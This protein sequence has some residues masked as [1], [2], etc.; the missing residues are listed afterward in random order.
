MALVKAS[1]RSVSARYEYGPFGETL[2][3]EETGV[4][5]PFRFSTKYLDSETGWYYY[6]YRYYDPVTGRWPSRDPIEE[7][8][9][10]NLYAFVKNKA[11]IAYDLLGLVG[12]ITVPDSGQGWNPPG[13]LPPLPFPRFIV[14]FGFITSAVKSE[15]SSDMEV[16]RDQMIN[17]ARNASTPDSCPDEPEEGSTVTVTL[18]PMS[19]SAGKNMYPTAGFSLGEVTV[20]FTGLGTYEYDCCSKKAISYSI[21]IHGWFS[22]DVDE[23]VNYN[24]PGRGDTGITIVGAF[25][26][27]FQGNF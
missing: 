19:S 2:V 27:T 26:K 9:G 6:G 8:G 3:V 13:D 4:S 15:S 17:S 18:S 10:V 22:D 12:S 1:D 16:L 21:T 14:A 20:N 11:V 24:E 25:E 5:N 23:L 7:R